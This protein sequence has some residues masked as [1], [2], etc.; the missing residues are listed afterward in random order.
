VLSRWYEPRHNFIHCLLSV[1]AVLIEFLVEVQESEDGK[2]DGLLKPE[3]GG[4]KVPNGDF[5]ALTNLIPRKKP[6]SEPCTEGAAF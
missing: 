5:A 1:V 6:E 4:L 2:L 3:V